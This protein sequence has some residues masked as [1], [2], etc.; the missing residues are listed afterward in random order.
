MP[1]ILFRH[2]PDVSSQDVMKVAVFAEYVGNQCFDVFGGDGSKSRSETLS[3]RAQEVSDALDF[4]DEPHF[5]HETIQK[6]IDL[7]SIVADMCFDKFGERGHMGKSMDLIRMDQEVDQVLDKLIVLQLSP[8][9]AEEAEADWDHES[10]FYRPVEGG[11]SSAIR[12][13]NIGFR[14]EV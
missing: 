11:N 2:E 12:R 5:S 13:D 4:G 6:I 10:Q 8:E 7:R 1:T 9:E 14:A 3:L